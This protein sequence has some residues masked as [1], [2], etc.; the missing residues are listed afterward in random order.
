MPTVDAVFNKL[1]QPL[2]L[3]YCN[4]GRVLE[5]GAGVTAFAVGDRVIS[6]GK[7]AEAVSVPV[8]LCAKVPDA[9]SDDEARSPWSVPSRCRAAAW[10][11][12]RWA[13]QWW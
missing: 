12:R 7:H 10:R 6:N 2:P 1:D 3:G 11:S 9:V 13:R 5:V 8:N 4:T